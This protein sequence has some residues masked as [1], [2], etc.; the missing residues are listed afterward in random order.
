MHRRC[1]SKNAGGSKLQKGTQHLFSLR[2]R[3]DSAFHTTIAGRNQ[4]AGYKTNTTITLPISVITE[5]MD[6]FKMQSPVVVDWLRLF[7]AVSTS[8]VFVIILFLILL[9]LYA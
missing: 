1:S 6:Q 9:F 5:A 4:A 7:Y 8:T 2:T 3:V